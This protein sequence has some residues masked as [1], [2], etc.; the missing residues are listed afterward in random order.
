MNEAEIDKL[1]EEISRLTLEELRELGIRVLSTRRPTP[2]DD[3][4]V[5][6]RSR[7]PLG[8]WTWP[9]RMPLDPLKVEVT[10]PP[11]AA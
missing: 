9:E 2:E 8:R 7:T 4:A 11:W 10:R 6:S 5:V 3:G 1:A